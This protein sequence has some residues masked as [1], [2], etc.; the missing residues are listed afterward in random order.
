MQSVKLYIKS[1]VK[2]H[3]PAFGRST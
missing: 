3:K 1:L 2:N